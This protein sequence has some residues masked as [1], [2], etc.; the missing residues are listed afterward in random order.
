MKPSEGYSYPLTKIKQLEQKE[1]RQQDQKNP[2][3]A[4]EKK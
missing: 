4:E 1:E 2:D 3:T